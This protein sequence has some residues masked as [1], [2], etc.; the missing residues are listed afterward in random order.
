MIPSKQII[1]EGDWNPVF[2]HNL[3]RGDTSSGTST[4]DA[5]YFR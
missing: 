3:D 1:L 4:L 5:R 2:D